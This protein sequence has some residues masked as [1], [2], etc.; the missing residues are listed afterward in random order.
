VQA[1]HGDLTDDNV[2]GTRGDDSRLHPHTVLDLGDLGLGWRVAELAVCA[3]SMLHHEPERPLRVIE[4]IAAFHRDAPLSVAEARAVWPLVVLR[5]AL[6]VASGWRQL[7]IDGDNDYARERIAGE[8]AIFDAATLLPLVE[9]T[10]HV[11]VAVGI[12]EGGFDAADLAA[13]AE[14]APLA[15]LLPDLTG[16]VAVIDPGVESAAL[17]G[18]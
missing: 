7:E 6:L 18:G 4:T 15:S 5:A 12:D 13:E 3:S 8:Q 17:D 16:R 11:L 2:M 10:E 9:M 14:V 1:I